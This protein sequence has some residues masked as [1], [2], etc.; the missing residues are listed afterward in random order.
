MSKYFHIRKYTSIYIYVN[1]YIDFVDVY[2]CIPIGHGAVG[3]GHA[4]HRRHHLVFLG[5][6]GQ[7][8]LPYLD[9]PAHKK[10]KKSPPQS[11]T[12]IHHA[13]AP[14]RV[15]APRRLTF[16]VAVTCQSQI[17]WFLTP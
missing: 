8:H 10:Q 4:I 2:L 3:T 16:E 6:V 5:I 12:Q 17:F 14:E 7:L 9:L 15:S 1:M 13:D 11:A